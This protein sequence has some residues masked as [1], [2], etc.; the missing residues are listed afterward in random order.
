MTDFLSQNRPENG[1]FG[2]ILKYLKGYKG[3]LVV[4]GIAIVMANILILVIPYLTKLVFDLLEKKA[5]AG[6][7]LKY[8]LAMFGLAI[9]SGI[10]RFTTRRTI[11]WMSRHLEYNLRGEL[12]AHLLK[13]SPS[14]YD[15]TRTG[16]IM[17]RATNDLEAVRKM[18]GPGI[19]YITNTVVSLVIAVGFMLYLSPRLTLYSLL[20]MLVFPYAVNKLGNLVH[21]K[22]IKIQEQ[23]S[24]ITATAQENLAGIR[25]VKAYG[26]EQNEYDNFSEESQKYIRHNLGMARLQGTL[27]PLIYFLASALN[28]LI[29]YFGAQEVWDGKIELGTM[30][31]FFAYLHG[32]FWPMFAMGWVVSLYQRG[33]ASLDRINRILFTE[34]IIKNKVEKPYR[35]KLKGKIEFKNLKFGYNGSAVLDGIDLVIEPSQTVGVVGMTGSGKSTLAG[36]LA[37]LY[38]VE[39]NRLYID[40]IDINKWDLSTLRRQLGFVP[41]E[42]FLFSDTVAKNILFGAERDDENTLLA[43]ARTAALDKDVRDF[44]GGYG[45]IVGERGITLSGGQKQRAA[46]ARALAVSPGILV[47]D[48]VTSSVDTETENEIYDR[49]DENYR[50]CTRIIISHRVSSVKEADMII[51]LEDGRIVEQGGHDELMRLDGRYAELYR[52]QLLEME[53]EKL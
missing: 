14:Y 41:Q 21:R 11:V 53:I 8:V 1:R 9:L 22:F 39:D 38:L 3:Y 29:L 7:I 42:P 32:L 48:D 12:V 47:L 40:D 27:F 25:V 16:D 36:L 24:R 6:E 18:T 43:A 34:P 15:V 23:F 46:I 5:P 51:F 10:F 37:R 26:Q 20:P 31:A 50:T 33:T 28:L 52:S 30:V 35:G 2:V 44:P 4:G 17:A 19:M 45:T 49:L 13:L